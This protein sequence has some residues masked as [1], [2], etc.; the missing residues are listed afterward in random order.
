[1]ADQDVVFFYRSHDMGG[2]WE[3]SLTS[4]TDVVEAVDRVG[5]IS[6]GSGGRERGGDG[7]HRWILIGTDAAYQEVSQ[8]AWGSV[9]NES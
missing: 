5:K 9:G 1:M 8:L 4:V 6:K 2:G 3:G 7:G